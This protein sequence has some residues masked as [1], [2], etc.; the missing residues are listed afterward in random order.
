MGCIKSSS[1]GSSGT[2]QFLREGMGQKKK[3]TTEGAEGPWCSP[4]GQ[5]GLGVSLGRVLTG[6]E[7]QG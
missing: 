4:G 3:N 7:G 6:I 5:E 1:S 2:L